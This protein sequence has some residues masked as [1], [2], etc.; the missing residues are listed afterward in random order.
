MNCLYLDASRSALGLALELGE[1]WIDAGR[2]DGRHDA[3]LLPTLTQ[4]LAA[5]DARLDAIDS[6]VCVHGPG[7]FTGLRISVAAVHAL[8]LV[9][10]CRVLPVDQ[11]SL[12]A[13]VAQL[14][15]LSPPHAV[16][17]DARMG[18]AY[19]GSGGRLS[20]GPQLVDRA[21]VP[22]ETLDGSDWIGHTEEPSFLP[23]RIRYRV[24]PTLSD[25]RRYAAACPTHQWIPGDLLTPL[26]LRQTISWI[27]LAEQRSKLYES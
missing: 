14:H 11:L 9:T 16:V 23:D 17:L 7:S 10:Q 25:L 1:T 5:H 4:L 13:F 22:V 20:D 6:V 19:V 27:P 26:Y 8:H 2:L 3:V 24:A 12:M 18:D 15:T 21:L